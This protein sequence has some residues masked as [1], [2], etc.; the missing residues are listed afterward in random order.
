[1]AA[2][3]LEKDD[4]QEESGEVAEWGP[5]PPGSPPEVLKGM[6][7]EGGSGPRSGFKSWLCHL[8]AVRP[9]A[10][11]FTSLSLFPHL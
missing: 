5:A 1:M 2:L 9:G 4:L 11:H 6:E 10:T 3:I 7:N 8:L